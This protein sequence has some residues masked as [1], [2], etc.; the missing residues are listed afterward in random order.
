[1]QGRIFILADTHG[2][3]A[4]I[5]CF[6]SYLVR[7]HK[8]PLTKD[9]III[10]LGDSGLNILSKYRSKQI[11]NDLS[12]YPCKYF[13][14]RGNHDKRPEDLYKKFPKEWRKETFF[15]NK[16]YVEKKYPNIKYALDQSAVY[17]INQKKVLVIPGAYSIDK[18]YRLIMGLPWAENEQLSEKEQEETYKIV[19]ELK[20]NGGVD[21]VLSHT[22]PKKYEP[23]DLF[24]PVV[25]QKKVDKTMEKLLDQIDDVLDYNLWFFGHFHSTRIYPKVNQKQQIMIYNNQAIEL[26]EA[27]KCCK[28]NKDFSFY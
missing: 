7:F 18:G 24:L 11:K 8:K 2:S 14:I 12:G 28:E 6:N 10:I 1:M 20:N 5:I 15:D 22:C 4:P 3:S 26:N 13:I 21:I 17:N 25:I 9:D 19:E 27:Y 16:V 23:E